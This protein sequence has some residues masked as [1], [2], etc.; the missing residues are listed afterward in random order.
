MSAK[1]H[2]TAIIH[3]PA[4]DISVRVVGRAGW[5]LLQLIAAGPTGLTTLTR[6]APRWSD[7]VFKLRRAGFVINT[8]EEGHEGTFAG[9]H[10]RYTLV[11]RVSVSGGNLAEWLSSPEGR[12]E[13]P[14]YDFAMSVAA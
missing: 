12:R 7:Y 1:L 6:P 3:R 13:L 14:R 11:D 8:A 10:G 4:D 2:F 5:G 9:H